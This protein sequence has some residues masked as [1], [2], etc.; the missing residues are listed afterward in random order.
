MGNTLEKMLKRRKGS[1][2][3]SLG[4]VFGHFAFPTSVFVLQ[5]VHRARFRDAAAS[6]TGSSL[7]L[8][9]VT[10]VAAAQ[11]KPPC[12][13]L[14]HKCAQHKATND[15]KLRCFTVSVCSSYSLWRRSVVVRV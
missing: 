2:G 4:S 1:G 3:E 11:K 9:A 15:Q 5:Q 13:N 10:L 6:H 7:L 12:K 14:V 8:S